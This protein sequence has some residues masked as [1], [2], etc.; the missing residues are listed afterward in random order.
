MIKIKALS[1]RK[2]V[3]LMIHFKNL[4]N[5]FLFFQSRVFVILFLFC[6]TKLL[7]IYFKN[8]YYPFLYNFFLTLRAFNGI[9]TC[10]KNRKIII[11]LHE[12]FKIYPYLS[13]F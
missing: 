13:R 12:D 8:F 5:F 2:K 9:N 11:K 3:K 10:A 6:F 4:D 7:Y 1:E